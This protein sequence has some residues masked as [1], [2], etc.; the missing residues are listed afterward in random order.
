[1]DDERVWRRR[2]LGYTLVRF[3]GLAIFFLGLAIV[4]TDLLRPGGWPQVGA[5]VAILGA[6]DALFAPRLLKK[7]WE[8]QD[9]DKE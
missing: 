9:R 7:S 4:Y 8:L 2:L 3:A 5:V 6:I 1:M